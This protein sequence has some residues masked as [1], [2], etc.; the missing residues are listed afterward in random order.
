M[1]DPYPDQSHWLTPIVL[2]ATFAGAAA[3]A[4]ARLAGVPDSAPWLE[5]LVARVFAEEQRQRVMNAIAAIRARVLDATTGRLGAANT[6]R[7]AG[8]SMALGVGVL[9]L[10]PATWTAVTVTHTSNTALPTAGPPAG[11]Q[12]GFAASLPG[13]P[14]GANPDL[15][16]YLLAHKGNARYL[17][18]TITAN[19]AAPIILAT[20]Q[21]VMSLGGFTGGDKILT[22]SQLITMVAQGQVRYFLLQGGYGLSLENI[23]HELSPDGA[24]PFPNRDRGVRRFGGTGFTNP[25]APLVSWVASYCATVPQSAWTTAAAGVFTGGQ[26]YMCTPSSASAFAGP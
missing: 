15:V 10:A 8:I 24:L 18:A 21:P 1:L 19:T 12:G 3:L 20:G 23:R 6:L 25:N 7:V 26:L 4:L 5:M 2:I 9:L 11:A 16:R 17:V 22:M 14:D 13:N